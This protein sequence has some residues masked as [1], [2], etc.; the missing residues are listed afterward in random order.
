MKVWKGRIESSN[1]TYST[2][3]DNTTIISR[4]CV[5]VVFTQTLFAQNTFC[6]SQPRRLTSAAAPRS[7][8]T[9]LLTPAAGSPAT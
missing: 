2:G 4:K 8:Q 7:Q 6:P 3:L 9:K 5:A 1:F